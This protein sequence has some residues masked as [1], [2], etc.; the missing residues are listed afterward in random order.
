[1]LREAYANAYPH[2][3]IIEG[4]EYAAR[5]QR[6]EREVEKLT[7]NGKRREES[8]SGLL[9]LIGMIKDGLRSANTDKHKIEFFD[10]SKNC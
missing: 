1:M 2:L 8:L 4:V 3:A 5:V 7:M 10:A 6:L 9:Q